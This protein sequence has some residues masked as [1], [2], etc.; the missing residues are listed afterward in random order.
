MVIFPFLLVPTCAWGIWS[1]MVKEQAPT[2]HGPY[3]DVSKKPVERYF[4][5]GFYAV[6]MLAAG[7]MGIAFK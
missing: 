4:L 1:T 7:G 5:A 6:L 3:V 2:K